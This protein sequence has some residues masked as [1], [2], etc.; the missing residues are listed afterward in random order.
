MIYPNIHVIGHETNISF[1]ST[2]KEKARKKYKYLIH[3][4]NI[5]KNEAV[6]IISQI[7]ENY[8]HVIKFLK[9]K[10]YNKIFFF[11]D[12]VFRSSLVDCSDKYLEYYIVKDIIKR[13]SLKNFE[14]FHCEQ[15]FSNIDSRIKYLDLFLADWAS[16]NKPEFP[17]DKKFTYKISC[18]NNRAA[19]HRYYMSALLSKNKNIF[20]TFNEPKILNDLKDDGVLNINEFDQKFKTLLDKQ[21]I[22]LNKTKKNYLDNTNTNGTILNPDVQNSDN[23]YDYITNSFVN[24]VTETT[25]DNNFRYVSEKTLKPMLCYRPFIMLGPPGNLRLIKSFGFRTFSP[26]WDESY[27]NIKDQNLRFKKVYELTQE[28]GKKNKKEL[29]KMLK[30]M[31][32]VLVHNRNQLEKFPEVMWSRFNV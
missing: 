17:F 14:I 21:L 18:L 2:G 10:K 20:L 23:V 5:K 13:I 8:D 22:F 15:T 6:I 16:R 25:F 7:I 32:P 19:V 28:I 24:L 27:D 30:D 31:K 1:H 11:I 12:D 29:S 26:W 3:R 9:T 4:F